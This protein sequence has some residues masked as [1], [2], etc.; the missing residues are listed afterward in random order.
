MML[1][2]PLPLPADVPGALFLHSMPGRHESWIDFTEA[3]V[4]A[5]I[6]GVV[7][8]VPED[9]IRRKSP[10]YH[11]TLQSGLFAWPR[12][13]FPIEDFGVPPEPEEFADFVAGMAARLRSGERLLAHC[14]AGIG[15]TGT[16]A[17]CLLL[18]FGLAAEVARRTVQSAG[19]NP[20]TDNQYELTAWYN[21]RRRG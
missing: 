4:A 2:R 20:E 17:L 9:E 3:A 15:R 7:C 19:S 5:R 14:M 8:L 10:E 12:Y 13:C 11:A 16:F 18:E 1:F 6:D 21:R